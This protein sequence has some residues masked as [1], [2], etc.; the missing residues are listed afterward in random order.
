[1]HA[2]EILSKAASL[3]GGD[4][5]RTHGDKRANFENVARHWNAYIRSIGLREGLR[6]QDLDAIELTAADVGAMMV[7]LKIARTLSGSHNPDD[8]LDAAGYAGCGGQ[9][10][11]ELEADRVRACGAIVE[12][13]H[14]RL[15]REAAEA[16]LAT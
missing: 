16:R 11:D 14:D 7:L 9:V 4:R 3:V 13:A 2:S 6:P 15:R 1:M 5:E 8:W 12:A 10:A